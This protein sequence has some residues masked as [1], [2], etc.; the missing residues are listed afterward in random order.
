MIKSNWFLNNS[1]CRVKGICEFY[2]KD[3]YDSKEILHYKDYCL[4]GGEDCKLKKQ[5]DLTRKLDDIPS[6][7]EMKEMKGGKK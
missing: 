3:K 6:K 7:L 2:N 4:R 1:N 5:N